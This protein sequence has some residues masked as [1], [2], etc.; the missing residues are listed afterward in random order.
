[1]ATW[2]DYSV[3]LAPQ[4][5][6]FG[7]PNTTGA[8][9]RTVKCEAPSFSFDTAVTET[10]LLT[11]QVGA[12]PERVIGRR[13]GTFG[14][15]IPLEGFKSGYDPTLEN[16]GSTGVIP[17]WMAIVANAL[18]SNVAAVANAAN[19]WAGLHLNNSTY[20]AS[21]VASATTTAITY[22]APGAF[23]DVDAGDLVLTAE[24][25]TSTTLQAR[26]REVCRGQRGYA[27]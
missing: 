21:G 6:G 17:P 16:P 26:F 9:Y 4:I 3:S 27:V 22:D 10:S 23:A 12:A 7:T 13:S 24:S 11:G 5:S 20:Q 19:F 25:P 2:S 18:G 15:K 14:F 8:D 1:M